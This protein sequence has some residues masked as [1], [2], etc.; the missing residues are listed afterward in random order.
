MTPF[1]YGDCSLYHPHIVRMENSSFLHY[2][3]LCGQSDDLEGLCCFDD[4][5]DVLKV[6]SNE[7]E[8]LRAKYYGEF[9]GFLSF[10]LG[11]HSKKK[12]YLKLQISV[13]ARERGLTLAGLDQLATFGYTLGKKTYLR[14]ETE[15][16][17]NYYVT[18]H[19]RIIE[20]DD[21]SLWYDQFEKHKYAVIPNKVKGVYRGGSF[22]GVAALL[23]TTH[24][25]LR[26]ITQGWRG[27]HVVPAWPTK[28]HASANSRAVKG[29]FA[30][31]RRGDLGDD[32]AL[33]VYFYK[34][35][36]ITSV[37]VTLKISN[38]PLKS[39]EQKVFGMWRCFTC[40]NVTAVP[41]M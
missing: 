14:L 11:S 33:D 6:D 20:Q 36:Y 29:M 34:K 17:Q 18:L 26:H 28:L 13:M 21:Q 15:V 39:D 27:Q 19:A 7:L 40:S 10:V 41:V 38:F 12:N 30:K 25:D 16:L 32:D 2:L 1:C 37:T 31:I 35:Y 4:V 24:N 3:M 8:R 22:T 9:T 5:T 23:G